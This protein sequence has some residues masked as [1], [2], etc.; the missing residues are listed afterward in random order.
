MS[1]LIFLLIPSIISMTIRYQIDA[2]MTQ[3]QQQLQQ[4][5]QQL[6]QPQ[7]Q[8]LYPVTNVPVGIS[9]FGIAHN[10][11][12]GYVYV[13]NFYSNSISVIDGFTN[14]LV[15][16]IPLDSNSFPAGIISSPANGYVYVTNFYSPPTTGANLSMGTVSVINGSTNSIV[17]T[18]QVGIS[19][20]GIAVN[21]ENGNLYVTNFYS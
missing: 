2:Q 10:P 1:I 13:T 12:N 7:Q 9:P 8:L 6:Q 15:V 21:P 18:I 20:L 16:T 4:P 17:D 11:E 3:P 14:D 5:Q 19:P